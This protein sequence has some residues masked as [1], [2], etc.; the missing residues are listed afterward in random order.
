MYSV[1]IYKSLLLIQ[2]YENFDVPQVK[3]LGRLFRGMPAEGVVMMKQ[4]VIEEALDDLDD[5][6][7]NDALKNTIMEKVQNLIFYLKICLSMLFIL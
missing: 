7:L 1:C 6:D 4:D 2:N 3:R 5:M